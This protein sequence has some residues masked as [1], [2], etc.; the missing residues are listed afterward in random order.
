MRETHEFEIFD[1]YLRLSEAKGW[2]PIT[3]WTTHD[4]RKPKTKHR[5]RERERVCVGKKKGAWIQKKLK[6]A[7]FG[8]V[9]KR[10]DEKGKT[11][12]GDRYDVDDDEI[13]TAPR[14]IFILLAFYCNNFFI[15][16]IILIPLKLILNHN[17][18]RFMD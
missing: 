15:N 4:Q 10:R 11:D 8:C 5:E 9:A 17:S 13:Y 18:S 1:E 6:V 14:E 3:R 16:K 12:A 2:A 7:S